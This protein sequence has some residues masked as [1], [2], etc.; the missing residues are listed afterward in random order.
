MG[1]FLF[2]R[3][4]HL[5]VRT[6]LESLDADLLRSHHCY[7]GGGTAIVLRRNEYR[8]SVDVNF[9]VSDIDGYRELRLMLTAAEGINT[10]TTQPLQLQR[11]IRADHYG[12]RTVIGVDG[13]SVKFEVLHEGRISLDRPSAGEAVCGV[14]TLSEL[15]AAA[16]KLLAN[17]D[18]WA[19]PYVHYRDVIDLA[20]LEPSPGVLG[21]AIQKASHA[22]G[23]SI[24]RC[25]SSVI[26]H[27]AE[28]PSRLAEAMRRLQV[29][30]TYEELW[31]RIEALRPA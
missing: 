24:T 25:L 11:G 28:N 20:M 30:V 6:I 15:D 22:Y 8:E 29:S 5:A 21:S 10:I 2:S 4:H 12:I 3:P 14:S 19:D 9:L 18:R 17:S 13:T 16:S 31:L 23:A 26:D 27:L 1:A 7:F